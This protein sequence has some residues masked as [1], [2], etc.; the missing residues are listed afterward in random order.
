MFLT[1]FVV[2]IDNAGLQCSTSAKC[3]RYYG[4]QYNRRPHKVCSHV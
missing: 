4:F 2:V 1:S 3:C